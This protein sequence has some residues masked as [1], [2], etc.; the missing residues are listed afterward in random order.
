M[1]RLA[2]NTALM[3][4]YNHVEEPL[5]KNYDVPSRAAAVPRFS[6]VCNAIGD[7]KTR[8][9]KSIISI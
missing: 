7:T 9:S 3:L 4:L 6:L 8:N 5:I 1:W 2:W